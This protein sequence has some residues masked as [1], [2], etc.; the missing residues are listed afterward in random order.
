MS[1]SLP[2]HIAIIMDGNR[3]WA[4]AKKLSAID[5]HKKV[6]NETLES[7]INHAGSLGI[8]YI[9]FWAFSTENWK[10]KK[11]EVNGLLQLF[12]FTLKSYGNKMIKKGARINYIGNLEK[13]PK[14]I[15]KGLKNLMEKSKNNKKITVTFAINYGG[16][17]EIIR[18][19]KKVKSSDTNELTAKEFSQYLDT[20]DLPDPDLIIRPGGEN[21]LSGFLLWQSEYAE[22]YFT[23]TLMPDFT[24][25]EL[26]IALTW[27]SHRT[28]RFGGGTFAN[29]KG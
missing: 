16:R 22:L 29:Y 21:R 23:D 11:T 6:A 17:D 5:G 13:F 20:A 19:I 28:R 1:K 14:D 7:L 9:T 26:D 3:R 12:R 25:K 15:Q 8:P 4:A 24:P 2:Q 10:R 18:A 27:Y